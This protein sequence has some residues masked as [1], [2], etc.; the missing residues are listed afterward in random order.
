[1]RTHSICTAVDA[2]VASM[3]GGSCVCVRVCVC[4][5]ACVCVCSLSPTPGDLAEC[6]AAVGAGGCGDM[7]ECGVNFNIPSGE[8]AGRVGGLAGAGCRCA[9]R[10][11]ASS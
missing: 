4:V 3:C 1:M 6:R 8:D 11:G 10:C 2:G 5:C 7:S 9:F